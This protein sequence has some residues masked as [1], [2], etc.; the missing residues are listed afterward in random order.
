MDD[1]KNEPAFPRPYSE[2]HK[3]DGLGTFSAQ[4]G[5]TKR[6]YFAG[7]AMQGILSCKK[8]DN[9]MHSMGDKVWERQS[10]F[11]H[12][13]THLAIQMADELLKKLNG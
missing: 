8:F 12:D 4:D 2:L 1:P 11:V 6:E 10:Q 5:L 9:T 13:N 7:L 3:H